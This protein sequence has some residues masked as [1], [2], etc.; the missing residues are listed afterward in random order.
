MND[1]RV[2][3]IKKED[4]KAFKG[5]LAIIVISGIVGGICGGMSDKLG[6]IFGENLSNFFIN[7]LEQITPYAS[8]VLSII[9]IIVSK[10][11][12]TKS[13]K[14][15]ELWKQR[16][17]DDDVIDKIEANLYYLI[18]VV[19]VNMILGFFFVGAGANVIMFNRGNE[20]L[21]I[22]KALLLL[23][24]IIL[25]LGSS[26]LIQKKVVN[27]EKEINPLLK[28]SVY[29]TNFSKKW[30]DS[31]DESIK[32]SI[33]KSAYKSYTSVS[34]TCGILWLF[35]FIGSDLWN[36]GVMP[37]VMVTII[38]LVLTVSYC[39]ESIKHSKVR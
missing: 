34:T 25:S 32:L 16:K 22:A 21:D 38:W 30:I 23:I 18:L 12:Y 7:I 10:V 6:E 3:E 11:I 27:L 5:F 31:C 15:Y 9:V 13:R 39:I 4:K 17:E 14:E 24:G 33:Y 19:A 2:S 26:V 28:G 37:L 29:D 36:L 35:C 1:N 8:I 20:E